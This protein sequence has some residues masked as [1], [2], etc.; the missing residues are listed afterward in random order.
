MRP[1]GRDLRMFTPGIA[2]HPQRM[3]CV[4]SDGGIAIGSA[5]FCCHA[6]Q[7]PLAARPARPYPVRQLQAICL[8]SGPAG[9]PTVRSPATLCG[10]PCQPIPFLCPA[11]R[12]AACHA[13]DIIW[14]TQ[15]AT[16]RIRYGNSADWRGCRQS[17][18]SKAGTSSGS[19]CR[20]I[21]GVDAARSLTADPE[22]AMAARFAPR[23][24]ASVG[25]RPIPSAFP[26]Y[27][28]QPHC[29][30]CCASNR[31][32]SRIAGLRHA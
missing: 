7:R 10:P 4:S 22:W 3:F 24:Q 30:H 17:L 13:H 2:T 11:R 16:A 27:C 20:F 32:A 8:V 1:A 15:S 19:L 23:R 29:D 14:Q 9:T 12:D 5:D 25:T 21:A 6:H 31:P 18:D 28:L 26:R